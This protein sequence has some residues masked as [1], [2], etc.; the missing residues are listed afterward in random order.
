VDDWWG[1]LFDVG[2]FPSVEGWLDSDR[3]AKA[4]E[5]APW[6]PNLLDELDQAIAQPMTPYWDE[7]VEMW[8]DG[9]DRMH[10]GEPVDEV[11]DEVAGKM[12]EFLAENPDA[13]WEAGG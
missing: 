8:D 7:L 2:Y 12:D 6:I 1:V 5:E 9:L 11:L 4:L 10:G 3:G 13:I